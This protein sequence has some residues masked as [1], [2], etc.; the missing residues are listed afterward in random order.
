FICL[1][2][3]T[4][5]QLIDLYTLS[6]GQIYCSPE[7]RSWFL[8]FVRGNADTTLVLDGDLPKKEWFK[9]ETSPKLSKKD[10]EIHTVVPG[11]PIGLHPHTVAELGKE[12]IHLHFYGDF[13]HGQWRQWIEKTQAMAPGYL[14][15][16]PNCSQESWVKEFSQYDAGWLHFFQSRNR[17]ELLRAGGD[18]LN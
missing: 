17:G 7:M 10:G 16:H 6:D 4:W 5:K 15:I 14:H 11:R 18:E 8:Q 1:E 13:T 12:K 3:G 9:T 2:K